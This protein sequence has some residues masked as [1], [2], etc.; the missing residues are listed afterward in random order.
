MGIPLRLSTGFGS[1][2]V[3]TVPVF[4]A[5]EKLVYLVWDRPSVDGAQLRSRYLDEVAP[6]LLA[7]GPHQLSMH[8]D[9]D[10]API[11]GPAPAPGHELPV[12][13]AISLFVDAH[14]HRQ[15]YEE[16][17]ENGR[18]I[19]RPPKSPNGI[20]PTLKSFFG[21]VG[22]GSWVAWKLAED[23]ANPGF[24]PVVTVEDEFGSYSVS[25][26]PL[27]AEQVSSF[28]HITSKEAFWP[29]LHSFKDRYNYDPV[30]WP[31]FREVNWLF[32]EAAARELCASV[33]AKIL[34]RAR[35]AIRWAA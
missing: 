16:V 8:L 33:A 32:A 1:S 11:P 22:R 17:E 21:K 20:V 12:R 2:P 15:P 30:D 10:E 6:A 24:E 31:T 34:R 27:T 7:L 9:D 18:I 14:D 35:R 13:A 26:L 3:V 23:P 4:R 28:Y 5:V 29:I 19:R 25:R